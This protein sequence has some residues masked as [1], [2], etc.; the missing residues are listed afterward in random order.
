MVRCNP[1]QQDRESRRLPK[2]LGNS[3]SGKK[4]TASHGNTVLKVIKKTNIPLQGSCFVWAGLSEGEKVPR[5]VIR[6]S[7]E[8]SHV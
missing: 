1:R 2:I 8:G 5:L 3:S 4:G 7:R 6:V